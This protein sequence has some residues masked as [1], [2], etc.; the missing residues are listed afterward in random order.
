MEDILDVKHET[1][2]S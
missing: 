2:L 1:C